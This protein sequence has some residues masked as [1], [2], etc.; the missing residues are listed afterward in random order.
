M[1]TAPADRPF[2]LTDRLIV[3]TDRR[4]AGRPLPE[5]VAA[6]V[7]GG[8]RLVVL[9]E[10]DLPDGERAAL[11][12]SLRALLAPVGGK[13]L[14]AGAGTGG[15]ADAGC[16]GGG[17]G[18]SAD[19]GCAGGS[20]GFGGAWCDG[21]HLAVADPFPAGP[22][23]R[24]EVVGRSCHD[25][26]ELVRA[27]AEGATYATL[28]PVLPTTSKPGYGPALGWSGLADLCAGATLPV[29]ALGG[30]ETAD[31]AAR[32]QSA[33]AAGVAVMGAVMRA[34]DPATVV[35]ELLGALSGEPPLFVR[36][37][38]RL[39][40]FPEEGAPVPAWTVSGAPSSGTGA[41]S[42]A[43]TTTAEPTA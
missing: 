20:G 26:A 41:R 37:A 15:S 11:A 1:V 43:A 14:L 6:A 4:Q 5:V 19:A 8:A 28:S 38:A 34:A 32:C 16:A 3:F 22:P 2:A 23:D 40:A 35:A 9:R 13:L 39:G 25:A 10:K 27:G 24:V 42:R 30:V 36:R 29:Y 12:A 7:D 18:G 33:G 21:R 31:Q 17:G